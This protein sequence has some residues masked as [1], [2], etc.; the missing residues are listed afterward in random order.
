MEDISRELE[1][2]IAQSKPRP[3]RMSQETQILIV[4]N[5]GHIRSG[6]HLRHLAVVLSFVSVVCFVAAVL[7]YFFYAD[8]SK[9]QAM[10]EE[11]LKAAETKVEKLTREKE[12]L[13][14]R[15][16]ISG[17]E[18]KLSEKKGPGKKNASA[19]LADKKPVV[20]KKTEIRKKAAEIVNKPERPVKPVVADSLHTDRS[21]ENSDGSDKG[22]VVKAGVSGTS[23][24]KS[25]TISV[26]KFT[27][28]NDAESGDV[29][30]RFDIRNISTEPGDVSG[31]IFTLL[32]P[33]NGPEDK[34]LVV[35]ASQLKNGI[36]SDYKKGQYF[37][38]AHFKPVK[39]RIKNQTAAG[40]GFFK[41][42][43]IFI[44]NTNGE[45]IFQKAIDIT[46][47]GK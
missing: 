30:V 43:S 28:V 24:T 6:V 18:L 9:K 21:Q 46:E 15:I 4:D 41:K 45:L 16:V 5:F 29:L 1:R 17:K 22:R 35:P 26:E 25:S 44:F 12:V 36:P 32:K 23:G 27:V 3:Y 14:A 8:L 39:F 33:D 37:S 47:S 2:Q 10:T 31:R 13:M 19:A 38:I 11:K 42:A 20:S 34:W 40:P 7:F